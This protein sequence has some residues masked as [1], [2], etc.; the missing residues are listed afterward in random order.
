MDLPNAKVTE[1][2][3]TFLGSLAQAEW[4]FVDRRPRTDSYSLISLSSAST[5]PRSALRTITRCRCVTIW[6]LSSS[7]DRSPGTWH[8]VGGEPC[9]H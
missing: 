1:I 8:K 7:Y 6:A 9:V 5:L 3:P 4:P 2:S